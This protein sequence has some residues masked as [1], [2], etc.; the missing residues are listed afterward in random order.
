MANIVKE[1]GIPRGSFYQY[2]EDK[3]DA[4]FYLLN[5]LTQENKKSLYTRYKNI[6]VIYLKRCLNFMRSS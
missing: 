6:K 3:E 2:F 1:A 4:F 5:E